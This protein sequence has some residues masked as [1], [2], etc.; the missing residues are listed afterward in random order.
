MN[1]FQLAVSAVVVES[2]NAQ[3]AQLTPIITV[4]VYGWSRIVTIRLPVGKCQLGFV[5]LATAFA[6]RSHNAKGFEMFELKSGLRKF[7]TV[8]TF[9][10]LASTLL[11][12]NPSHAA[13]NYSATDGFLKQSFS[14]G[15]RY[16]EGFTPGKADF[17]F[18][19][20]AM[21]QRYSLG[22]SS[23]D[24]APAINYNLTDGSV[25]GTFDV[26]KGYLFD[27]DGKAKLGMGGKFAFVSSVLKAKNQSLRNG[28]LNILKSKIDRSGDFAPDTN[29]NTFDRAWV[30]LA[31][32]SNGFTKQASALAARM[33]HHQLKD[34]GFNDGYD[35]GQGS[36]DGTGIVLQALAAVKG[37]GTPHQRKSAATAIKKAVAYLQKTSIDGKYFESW[38]DFNMNGTVYAAMGLKA[39][40]AN[41]S[42]FR[43]WINSKLATDGGLQTPWSEGAGDT[44]ATA[45][46]AVALLGKSYLDLLKK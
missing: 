38:G 12:S 34:G 23:A 43:T 18:T 35:L 20:E 36:P 37:Q 14:N 30:V 3:Q 31:L 44:Y 42:K 46:G 28:I 25:T 5:F 11:V 17:G 41:Y 45:Q 4:E 9:V 16:V 6:L 22:E 19:L 8:A 13:V 26:P 15:G 2:R 10:A 1:R 7:A 21:L 39:V 24:L 29:A 27:A 40:G 32:D 33:I